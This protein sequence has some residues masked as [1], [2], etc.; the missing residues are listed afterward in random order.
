MA[1]Q[2]IHERFPIVG[3]GAS[4][5]GVAALEG[6]FKGVPAEPEFAIVIVTHLSP[7]RKSY[8]HEIVG[9]F[10]N[11]PVE[12]A[13]DGT[14]VAMGKVYVLP[15][16]TVLGIRGGRLR[17]S[18]PANHERRPIDIFL[19]ALAQDQG[20]YSGAVILSGADGDGTLGVKAIKERG[21]ITLAQIKDGHG[22]SYSDMPQ[23]AISSGFVD[24]AIPAEAMGAELEQFTRGLSL[25]E[26]MAT[27]N[28]DEE[29]QQTTEAARQNICQILL[30]QVG[31]DFKGYKTRTF[32]RRVQRRMQVT[33]RGTIERYLDLL[34]QD[35]KE[36]N[37]LFRDLLINVT[38]FF[39]DKEAFDAL[40]ELVIPQLF[41]DRGAS[42][43]VRVWV[44]G[45]ATGEEVFSVAILMREY[46]DTLTAVPRIQIFAT[47]IDEKALGIARTARYPEALLDSV[48]AERRKRFFHEDGG[49]FAVTKDVRDLCVFS[50]HSVIRDPPFSRLDLISCRNLLI[51]FGSDMQTQVIPTF[52]YSLRPGGYLFLGT[53]ENVSQYTGLFAAVDKKQRIFR[54]R[55][56]K[57]IAP[58]IPSQIVGLPRQRAA[59]SR[60]ATTGPPRSLGFRQS[61]ETQVLDRFAPAHVVADRNGDVVHYSSRTGRYLE[62]AAGMPTRQI[63][64][65]ARKGLRLDLR[66][67]FRQC[68]ENGR[69]ATREHVEMEG[70]DG[71]TQSVTIHVEPLVDPQADE[72][73]FVVLFSD[74]GPALSPEDT[75]LRKH[76]DADA[77]VLQLERDLREA[78]ERLQSIVEEYETAVE[79]LKSS[80][81]ELVSVNE[82]LQSTNEELEASKEELQSLN[83]ELHTVN[84][85]LHEKIDALD[86]ANG[87]LQNLFENTQVAMIFLD[88]DLSIRT[89]TPATSRVFNVLPSDRG[90]PITDLNSQLSLPSLK[91]DIEAAVERAATIERR[92]TH[93]KS[94]AHFLVRIGPYRDTEERTAGG[95]ITFVDVTSLTDAEAHQEILI[96]ELNHRVRNMLSIVIGLAEQTGRD[97]SSAKAF[98]VDFIDRIRAMSRAYELLTRE[99]WKDTSLE[100]LLRYE[101]APFSSHSIQIQGPPMR[102][103]PKQALSIGMVVHELATNSA[104]YGSLSV[105]AGSLSVSWTT[106]EDSVG[107]KIMMHWKETGGP[108]VPET[109]VP[110]FGLR[111]VRGE[112]THTLGGRLQITNARSGIN[113]DFDFYGRKGEGTWPAVES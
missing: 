85:E 53:S 46:M 61:I 38:N 56:D 44:P 108:P 51:Y 41:A 40:N 71:R 60:R 45:C 68:I 104:K 35:A 73:F 7:E 19:S 59:D 67:V 110:G 26:R 3:V 66:A 57:G 21:G 83:E 50:P 6:F 74:E 65:L 90:R 30:N 13:E 82:E 84:V 15:A 52:H 24:F 102:L 58:H 23:S 20:E 31:H 103:M 22:P 16:D 76:G 49:T 14:L 28:K 48:S 4:A 33:Q 62:A 18:Q 69:P 11:M 107:E 100:D 78:R 112:I 8:L 39:R 34:R 37:A 81:E 54:A 43:V 75:D 72:P 5:G 111:L 93:K 42:D 96:A 88:K 98:K 101:F 32:L 89:F 2:A 109:F 10:S 80:N 94:G 113:L 105:P 79:E 70:D 97:D 99:N 9:R 55:G 12:I 77:A 47:D 95:V 87:D 36:V 63:V 17:I 91:D 106:A 27:A 29:D 64:S 25:F 86:A 92:T 1:A